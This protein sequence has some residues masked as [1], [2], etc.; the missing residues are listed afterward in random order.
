MPAS[1][2]RLLLRS[3]KPAP[4]HWHP[5][6]L[7]ALVFICA[8]PAQPASADPRLRWDEQAPAFLSAVGKLTVPGIR[9]E[10]GYSRHVREDCSG[11]L[12]AS[13]DNRPPRHVLTAWHCIEHYKDLSKNI[14]FTLPDGRQRK[15]RPVE[16]GGGM[17]ADWA[18]LTLDSPLPLSWA[19]DVHAR[20][21]V[22]RQSELPQWR[23]TM[24]GFS[25]DAGL[26]ADGEALTYHSHCGVI[27][28]TDDH[29][30]TNC[31]AY[32]GA[33]GGAVFSVD[34]AGEATLR[35][36]IS[37]GDGQAM[38]AYMPLSRIRGRLRSLMS[39]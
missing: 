13:R 33:S 34:E 1:Q 31:L 19:A 26:G 38:S 5:L 17:G 8:A 6:C 12:L 11:T 39:F 24:A 28:V 14:I 18:L 23:L 20:G 25:G 32:K 9:I 21:E 16:D 4:K 35:G 3:Y 2:F 36:V 22:S 37:A 29:V 15:A 30:N 7:S 10:S 27:E